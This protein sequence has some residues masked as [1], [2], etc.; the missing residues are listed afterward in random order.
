MILDIQSIFAI[1][2]GFNMMPFLKSNY[3]IK[4]TPQEWLSYEMP[5][6]YIEKGSSNGAAVKLLICRDCL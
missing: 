4:H 2:M 5:Y 1:S 3:F 6:F